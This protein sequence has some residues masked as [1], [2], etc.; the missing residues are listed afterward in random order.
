MLGVNDLTEAVF[1]IK[2]S[3]FPKKNQLNFEAAEF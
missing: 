3:F 2:I 1:F